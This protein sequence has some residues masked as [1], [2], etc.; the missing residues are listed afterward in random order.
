MTRVGTEGSRTVVGTMQEVIAEEGLMGLS[1]G[2]GPRVLHS[3]C[4]AAIGYCA[5]ETARLAILKSYLEGCERKAA[6]EMKAG[7]AAA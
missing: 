5:F 6:E 2:I 3:A 4:F 1:R 7:V